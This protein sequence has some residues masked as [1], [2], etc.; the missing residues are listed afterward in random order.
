MVFGI[1]S[2]TLMVSNYK[3]IGTLVKV[4][5][6]I[7][8]EFIEPVNS[9]QLIDGAIGGIVKSLGDPYSIYMEPKMFTSLQKDLRGTFGGVG[10]SVGVR[11]QHLTVIAPI[12]GT[13]AYRHG[14][15]AGDVIYKIDDKE[16]LEM[17]LEEAVSRIQGKEGT[18]VKLT[19]LR[20]G[21]RKPVEFNL[22]REVIVAPSV[23]GKILDKSE[24]AYV[25]LTQF[26]TNSGQELGKVL[27]ELNNEGFKGIILDLRD[28]PGG[29]LDAAVAVSKYFVPKGP[30][31][32]IKYRNGQEDKY[33]SDTEPLGVPLVVLINE[34]SASA[35]E[36]VAG[37]I[38]DTKAG[39]LV[40]T[41]SFGKGV[42]QSI[43][44]LD[45]GAGLKLT[46]AKYYTP[47]GHDIHKKGIKPDVEV[48]LPKLQEDK[49]FKDTQL[50]KAIEIMKEK[51]SKSR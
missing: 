32:S 34:N 27:S 5:R 29:D 28:N 43:F 45:N 15:K 39:V 3:H 21:S 16:A 30:I 2:A 12:K 50:D 40:G 13:P 41:K 6:I 48:K 17:D 44:P 46:T 19:M 11:E 7:D 26:K 8:R 37:A 23:E 42:V 33:V 35:S 10:I 1:A 22:T 20:K 18:K 14:V 4:V 47:S 51:I 25:Q 24:I 31:V 38:K 36:I 9:A 49:E